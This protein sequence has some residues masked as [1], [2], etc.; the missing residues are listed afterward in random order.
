MLEIN[1]KAVLRERY[2]YYRQLYD[3]LTFKKNFYCKYKGTNIVPTKEFDLD[4]VEIGRYSYG[5]LNVNM[6]AGGTQKLTI[7]SFV[8][9]A[10]E[11]LF[12]LGGVHTYK[13]ISSFPFKSFVLEGSDDADET[14]G[15]IVIKDDVWIA[16]RS[17]I[18]SGVTV[19][20]GAI[21]A[22]GSV[23]T[24]DVPAYAI[25]GGNPAKVINYRFEEN[26]RNQLLE[27][28]DYSKLNNE[29]VKEC[30]DLLY[31]PITDENIIDIKKIFI[32]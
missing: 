19:N 16:T 24:K 29:N 3:F 9:I 31:V 11:V 17:M 30:C 5:N 18:L 4:R 21:I 27:F 13:R 23:V 6:W 28:V 15:S 8:S 14:R 7:G 12:V 22:A 1:L 20:Q 10:T 32:N 26:I 2:I 25:V